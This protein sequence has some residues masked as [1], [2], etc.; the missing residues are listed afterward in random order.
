MASPQYRWAMRRKA[1]GRC[2]SCGRERD[3][4][5]ACRCEACQ[6]K[7]RRRAR[8]WGKLR[9]AELGG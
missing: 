8:L 6:E 1:E 9:R 2:I 3:T 7:Q 5:L 4:G